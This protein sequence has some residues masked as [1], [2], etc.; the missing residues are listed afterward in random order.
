MVIKALAEFHAFFWFEGDVEKSFEQK[1]N[2][3]NLWNPGSYWNVARQPPTQ[4]Q[5]FVKKLEKVVDELYLKGTGDSAPSDFLEC[6]SSSSSSS[7]SFITG[8]PRA[9]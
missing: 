9:P 5:D 2:T 7:S 6:S 4:I 3:Q 1:V 8:E